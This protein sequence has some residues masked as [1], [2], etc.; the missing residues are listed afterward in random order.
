M[1]AMTF[2]NRTL[3][4]VN[5]P[6]IWQRVAGACQASSVD[7][8]WYRK[9]RDLLYDGLTGIG[10]SMVKPGG[11]FYLFPKSPIADDQKFVRMAL[12]KNLLLVP[13]SGFGT[14]GYFRI[15]YCTID[16]E[17]I[18]RSLSVFEQVYAEAIG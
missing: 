1:D 9:K 17:D 12:E 5:A 16:D 3:G 15:A 10:Y 14:A 7:V 11:A 13:G 8:G 18:E 2:T 4:F 6:A